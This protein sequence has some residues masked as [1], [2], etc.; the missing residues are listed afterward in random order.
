LENDRDAVRA[1]KT[2]LQA[3]ADGIAAL[4]Q[5]GSQGSTSTLPCLIKA[6]A[7]KI[8]DAQGK[9]AL[10]RAVEMTAAS[11]SNAKKA[12]K[13]LKALLAAGAD[14]EIQDNEGKTAQMHAAELAAALGKDDALRAFSHAG[15]ST[16]S[17]S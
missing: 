1:A 12:L 2:L 4:L 3:G 11:G 14:T 9:T 17:G 6:G 5:L 7:D 15:N 16:G 13:T 8:K 10:M